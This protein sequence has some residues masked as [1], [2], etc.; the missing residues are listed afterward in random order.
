MEKRLRGETLAWRNACMEERLRGGTL[1]WRNA[2]TEKRL[3]GETLA[4]RKRGTGGSSSAS[5]NVRELL[6]FLQLVEQYRCWGAASAGSHSSPMHSSA[7]VHR[8][9][10]PVRRRICEQ[11]WTEEKRFAH[12]TRAQMPSKIGLT[13][14]TCL[15]CSPRVSR[16]FETEVPGSRASRAALFRN[17]ARGASGVV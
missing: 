12:E 11:Y 3:R 14:T 7:E 2:C 17:R 1:A 10:I 6:V 15:G 16:A 9:R 5:R 13:W 8:L 4:R